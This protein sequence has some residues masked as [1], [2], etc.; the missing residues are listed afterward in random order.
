MN[1]I[2]AEDMLW[3]NRFKARLALEK[4][5]VGLLIQWGLTECAFE[6]YRIIEDRAMVVEE[7]PRAEG[8]KSLAMISPIISDDDKA[9]IRNVVRIHYTKTRDL[10]RHLNTRQMLQNGLLTGYESLIDQLAQ[11]Y[12]KY[13]RNCQ[14][15][16]FISRA[17]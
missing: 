6:I 4:S 8:Y 13:L 11:F 1:S 10:P 16:I 14:S 9:A 3:L 5:C 12:E 15:T 17:A 7:N 2:P